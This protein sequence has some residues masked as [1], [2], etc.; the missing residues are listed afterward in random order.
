MSN[1]SAPGCL[2]HKDNRN[3]QTRLDYILLYSS[4]IKAKIIRVLETW[5]DHKYAEWYKSTADSKEQE[6]EPPDEDLWVTMSYDQLTIFIYGTAQHDTI[7]QYVD[8]LVASGDI[9]RRPHP[10]IPYGPPQY[11][12]NLEKVQHG[13]D[14]LAIPPNLF[15][16]SPWFL[17]PRKK[18]TSLETYPPGRGIYPPRVGVNLPPGTGEITPPSNKHTKKVTKKHTKKEERA[19]SPSPSV[20]HAISSQSENENDSYR[21]EAT[22]DEEDYH[23]YGT[24]KQHLIWNCHNWCAGNHGTCEDYVAAIEKG[25]QDDMETDKHPVAIASI[26]GDSGDP[27]TSESPRQLQTTSSQSVQ[28]VP[29]HLSPLSS[30]PGAGGHEHTTSSVHT[31]GAAAVVEGSEPRASDGKSC[32]TTE[33]VDGKVTQESILAD[34][35]AVQG[36]PVPRDDRLRKAARELVRA[37]PTREELAGCMEWLPKTDRPGKPWYALHG[38]GL[39]DIA[40]KLGLYRHHLALSIDPAPLADMPKPKPMDIYTQAS[41]DP[42]RNSIERLIERQEKARLKRAQAQQGGAGI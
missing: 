32:V 31:D 41:L 36:Q 9:Q 4:E 18:H 13:L 29:A 20:P 34:W 10:D 25:W 12:L 8:E 23:F 24:K 16:L 1:D 21:H 35:D 19:A 38:V 3:V 11:L 42:E 7:K 39:W 33:R 37:S 15:D 27:P 6:Q 40:E 26:P 5:T 22:F 14:T 28:T 2:H 17:S 30:A